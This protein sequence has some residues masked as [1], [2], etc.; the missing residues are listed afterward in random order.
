MD[1]WAKN[2]WKKSMAAESWFKNSSSGIFSFHFSFC[3]SSS[4]VCYC[5]KIIG[6]SDRSVEESNRSFFV[7]F[8][9]LLRWP[10]V[11]FWT[12]ESA[13]SPQWELGPF[14]QKWL[15]IG[16]ILD[17]NTDLLDSKWLP[18]LLAASAASKRSSKFLWDSFLLFLYEGQLI[19]FI[20]LL[21]CAYSCHF[22]FLHTHVII[23]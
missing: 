9:S 3:S 7:P 23:G 20:F 17:I 5:S 14:P 12:P 16:C 11:F 13:V 21:G 15:H 6:N 4:R 19:Y 10:R 2:S 8:Q 18:L 22:Y 1:R